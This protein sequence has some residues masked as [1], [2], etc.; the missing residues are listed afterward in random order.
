LCLPFMKLLDE[1]KEPGIA[2]DMTKYQ[3]GETA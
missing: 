3:A 1:K 2:E